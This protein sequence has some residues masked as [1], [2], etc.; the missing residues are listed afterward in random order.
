L[1]YRRGGEADY[2]S[3][4]LQPVPNP[5]QEASSTAFA[6]I[7]GAMVGPR[8]IDYWIHVETAAGGSVTD[9]AQ[10]A[11]A[12]PRR[13]QVEI[14]SLAAGRTYPDLKHHLVSFP[15]ETDDTGITFALQDDLGNLEKSRWRMWAYDAADSRYVE[16]T[17]ETRLQTGRGYWLISR[18]R[19]TIDLE[20]ASGR[21]TPTVP[22]E[23]RLEPGW[24]LIANP[25]S[26][27]VAWSSADLVPADGL[28]EPPVGWVI[29]SGYRYDVAV[30]EPFEG[31]WLRNLSL[32]AVS[33]RIP[34]LEAQAILDRPSLL[35]P[36]HAS[37]W[38]L[39]IDVISFTARDRDNVA[40]TDPQARLEWDALDRSE[41][42][43]AP[44][45]SLSLYFPHHEWVEKG[46]RYSRDMRPES[47][48]RH[49]WRFDV[50][51][52]GDGPL[53]PEEIRLEFGGLEGLPENLPATLIDRTLGRT[54]DLH[55]KMDYRFLL[56]EREFV[57]EAQARFL[58]V[59]GDGLPPD[60]RVDAP[61]KTRLIQ[62]TPNPFR[63]STVIRY[64]L[65]RGGVA[66]V[67]VFDVRG[68]LLRVFERYHPEPGS[69]ELLWNGRVTGGG[70]APPGVYFCRLSTP[71]FS[72][73]SR[74]VRIR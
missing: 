11:A 67:T 12:F 69:Y 41:P 5:D 4:A 71:G 13:V 55:G 39:W 7:P 8:G 9:P 70:S 54:V 27:P 22:F 32:E 18:S 2:D 1:F 24:N 34:P 65:S 37:G 46:G 17:F 50:A 58:L 66:T 21:S 44:G 33:L 74:L 14:D 40:G 26:F 48:E 20:P 56:G 29:E 60:F 16:A 45:N 36:P 3:L 43:M 31:Y 61:A 52:T 25:F 10:N 64:D 42:P 53:P 68:R 38:K 19:H 15:A 59:V 63:E 23:I 73:M 35:S 62:S 49:L 47:G 6:R 30:L 72:E 51:R 28:L 57:S